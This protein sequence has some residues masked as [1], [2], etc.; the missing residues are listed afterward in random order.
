MDGNTI[1]TDAAR[2]VGAMLSMAERVQRVMTARPRELAKIDAVLTG[3]DVEQ[4]KPLNVGTV[5]F[6]DAARRLGV[7]RAT[8]YELV[9]AGRLKAVKFASW[10]RITVASLEAFVAA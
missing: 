10:S 2:P 1:G 7:G 4:A 8:V 9:R 3:A 6:S 5:S